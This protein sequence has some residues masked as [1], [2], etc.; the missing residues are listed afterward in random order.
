[1]AMSQ[2]SDNS[3]KDIHKWRDKYLDLIEQY[4][5]YEKSSERKQ[6]QMRRALVVV[7]LLAEGQSDSID[8]P[9]AT[10]RDAIKPQNEGRGLESSVHVLQAEV[11]HFEQQWQSQADEVLMSL[12]NASK[13]LL[14]LPCSSDEKRRIK[15][16]VNK[17]KE[18]LKQW[19]GY[20]KQLKAWS[21]LL[22]DLTI[23]KNSDIIPKDNSAGFLSRLFQSTPAIPSESD[24]PPQEDE[25][26]IN[27][28]IEVLV[29]KV[30][31]ALDG[32]E[33]LDYDHIEQ[34]ISTMLT[35]LLAQLV[36]PAR[37]NNQLDDLKKKLISKLNWYELV[38]LLE[39]VTHLVIDALGDGQE[40]FEYFLQGLDQSLETIQQLVNNASKG[41][42]KR[43]DARLVFEGLL[44]GQVD[45]IR[46]VVNSENDPG[47]LGHS[48]SEHLGLIIQAMQAFSS[49]E[50]H[51][52]TEFAEQLHH[53]QLK[54]DDMEKLAESAQYSIEEQRKK[55]MHDSLT[56]MP[57]REAYQQRLEQ[58]VKRIER[59]G[60]KLSL[61]VCDVD[62]FKRINDAY[63]HLAGD[64]VLKIIAN[65]L[66][67]NLRSTDFIARFGGEE[68]VALMPET[69]TSEAKIVAEKM[70]RKIEE[71][72]FNFKKE[73]VQIT[74]SFGISEFAEG[75][76]AD[77]VFSR[78]DKALYEAKNKGRNQI[79]LG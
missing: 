36:I 3:G 33:Q 11:N 27:S 75:E 7:S 32:E 74:V 34:E 17:S 47:Q 18:H 65:S 58:E 76:S 25:P 78:A 63:G 79:Q 59:Y 14:R 70:R 64:K 77:D 22:S 28:T 9:L 23:D 49:E 15:K 54:L 60:G 39:Q 48:I 42:I 16:I 44:K 69:S 68:F 41:Q 57:N 31:L 37:Y 26:D 24:S 73:P 1:M 6:D 56:G 40:E 50:Y 5:Q 46:S 53:M 4:E 51:R 20:G 67:R 52:E 45:S 61:M 71:S 12:Q 38:P 21:E 43:S 29:P 66:Q 62:L 10:L 19:S 35:N 8:K 72:P 2:E 55:A 30:S 13:N